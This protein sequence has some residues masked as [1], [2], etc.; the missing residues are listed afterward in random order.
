MIVGAGSG[1]AFAAAIYCGGLGILA[2][3]LDR[4]SRVHAILAIGMIVL[5]FTEVC[6]G[7]GSGAHFLSDVLYW[8]RLRLLAVAVLPG[9]W[10]LF[11]LSFARANARE[12]I[13]RWKWIVGVF[14]VVPLGL[15]TFFGADLFAIPREWNEFVVTVLPLGWSGR[16]FHLSVLLAC[17]IVL[18][19]LEATL[20][21]ASGTKRWRI[22]FMVL[23][24]GSWFAVQIYLISQTLLFAAVDLSLAPVESYAILVAA[25][26]ILISLFRDRFLAAEVY[27]SPAA[28][29]NS[30]ALSLVAAYL[31]AVGILTKAIDFFGLNEQLSLATFFVFVAL[32]GLAI[33]LLSDRLRLGVRRFV[34][35]NFTRPRYD[36]RREWMRFTERTASLVE[37]KELSTA[38][39]RQ[40]AETFGVAAVTLWLLD[41][42]QDKIALGGSTLLSERQLHTEANLIDGASKLARQMSSQRTV[43]DFESTTDGDALDLR[44][45]LADFFSQCEVRYA[46]PLVATNQYL[47]VMTLGDRATKE[48]F[49]LE[50][51][52]LL[53]TVADQSAGT[54]Q[55]LDLSRRLLKAKEMEAFQ[56]LSAFFTHDL[57]NL[58]SML[59]LTMQN[60]PANYDNPEFRKDAL[61]VISDSVG[62]MNE[63]CGRLA[64]VTKEL[65]LRRREVDLNEL[66]ERTVANINGSLRTPVASDLHPIPKIDIDP[67]QIEKVLVNLLLN[68]NEAVDEKGKI[69]VAT[70]RRRGWAVL[71]VAD[72]G[73]GMSEEFI[74]RSL[75]QPFRTTKSEGLGIGLFQCRRIVE[76]HR[77]RIEVVSILD[78]GTTF[79]VELPLP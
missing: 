15:A 61:R 4:R 34:I 2:F 54:L 14:F 36:Y 20:R 42:S 17:V 38:V 21:S 1:V 75:F 45:S 3:L 12:T 52:D 56:T 48:G 33:I 65:D 43:I 68:A 51:F 37:V 28:L 79:R 67:E 49:S 27:F 46:V 47:G 74:A 69:R 16:I 76:A 59:S 5:G 63:M 58:A 71:T 55:N 29:Y 39:V 19:N 40:V 32:V 70:D 8:E 23:G 35:R 24:V 66:V 31:I 60:L 72:N 41:E 78:Q 9:V 44:R 7:L 11:S 57:K 22:K 62:K 25:S 50:D 18:M 6:A 77:G 30:I 13:W 26:L 64:T 73:C 10:L 53:K